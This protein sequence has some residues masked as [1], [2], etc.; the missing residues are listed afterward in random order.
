RAMARFWGTDKEGVHF[1]AQH[2]QKHF[3]ELRKRR[4][5]ILEIEIGGYSDPKAGGESLRMWKSFFPR[6]QVVGIDIADKS[7]HQTSR[8]KTYCGSQTDPEFLE[9]VISEIGEP[10]IIIDDG[11]HLNCDVIT[12]FKILFPKLKVP[13]FYCIEDL[14]TSYWTEVGGWNWDGSADLNAE[15]TSVNFLKSLVDCLNYEEFMDPEYR[16][17][18]FDRHIVAIHFYHNLAIIEKGIN[19]EGSNVLGKRYQGDEI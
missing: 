11:S 9:R 14:Q 3:S 12:T 5:T 6:A 16:P 4:I 15:G 7:A 8:I 17:T 1:Y 13:G 2:Y 18:Y 19:D 10:D